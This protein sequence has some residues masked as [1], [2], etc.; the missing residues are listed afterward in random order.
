MGVGVKGTA[1][2]VNFFAH[3]QGHQLLNF[4]KKHPKY[5]IL[6]NKAG[7]LYFPG[8]FPQ[9]CALFII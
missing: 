3:Q 1:Y 5:V 6:K 8:F 7:H 4:F 2:N 9:P